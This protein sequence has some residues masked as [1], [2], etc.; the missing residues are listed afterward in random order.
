MIR[1]L[2]LFPPGQESTLYL[3]HTPDWGNFVGASFVE[4]DL[5]Q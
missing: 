1:K 2:T 5:P 3:E 4:V